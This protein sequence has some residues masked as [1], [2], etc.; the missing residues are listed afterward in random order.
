MCVV[1]G[2]S[3]YSRQP[4]PAAEEV[5]TAERVAPGGHR[6]VTECE[7]CAVDVSSDIISHKGKSE[8]ERLLPSGK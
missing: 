8:H 7:R 4:Q 6:C 3:Q 1:A 2:I 5:A